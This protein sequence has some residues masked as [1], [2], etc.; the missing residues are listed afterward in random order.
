M[1]SLKVLTVSVIKNFQE[2]QAFWES[3]RY[4]KQK[5]GYAFR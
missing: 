5:S 1:H 3:D 2:N 4:S